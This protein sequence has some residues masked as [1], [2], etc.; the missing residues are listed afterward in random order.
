MEYLSF[1]HGGHHYAV[2][3]NNV[4]YIAADTSLHTTRV[5]D[6]DSREADTIDF[7]GHTCVVLSL[8]DLIGE[9][10]DTREGHELSQ[11]LDEREQDHIRWLEALETAIRK[12]SEFTLARDHKLCAFGRWYQEY[13]PATEE[14]Q[15]LFARFDG[16]H[17]RIHAL[18]DELLALAANGQRDEALASLAHH[19]KTTLARLRDLFEDARHLASGGLRPTV[20]VLQRFKYLNDKGRDLIGL[21]VDHI[22]DVFNCERMDTS[23]SGQSWL[24]DFADGWLKDVQI[25]E[26]QV[27]ALALAPMRLSR[28]LI[29]QCT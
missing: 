11:L 6:G 15:A 17:Q 19:R 23:A 20:I 12:N 4:R 29:R 21:R 1:S 18:A 2:P 25:N 5:P 10:A 16:P 14:M 28:S 13:Q 22:G 26:Q 3:L 24:P 8:A 27:T 9:S 7:E